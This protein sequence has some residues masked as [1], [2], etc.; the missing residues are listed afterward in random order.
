M[1]VEIVP[2]MLTVVCHIRK[3]RHRAWD[4]FKTRLAYLVAA[5]NMAAFN[6][7][8]QWDCLKPNE[9][10]G[11]SLSIAR[12]LSNKWRHWLTKSRVILQVS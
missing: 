6:I 11:I 8:V 2:S 5:F 3:M 4:Y 12:S 7:F 9:Q 10:G 1:E